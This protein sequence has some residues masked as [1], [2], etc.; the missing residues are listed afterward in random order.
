M[1]R[2][3]LEREVT[4][5][6]CGVWPRAA[7]VHGPLE[8]HL[9]TLASGDLPHRDRCVRGG[10]PTLQQA[11]TSEGEAPR[12]LVRG[13]VAGRARNRVPNGRRPH[14]PK[15][16]RPDFAIPVRGPG[17]HQLAS[18]GVRPVRGR[19]QVELW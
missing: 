13:D 3:H 8:D 1:I 9:D 6:A 17:T 5:G 2:A 7:E 10:E 19:R 4:V 18:P 14:D 11:V 15:R 12:H 16:W